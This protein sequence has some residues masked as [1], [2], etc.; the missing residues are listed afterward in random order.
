MLVP[1]VANPFFAEIT[2]SIED[3]SNSLDYGVMICSTDNK[4]RERK[5]IRFSFAQ[6]EKLM[7]L[8]LLPTF[9]NEELIQELLDKKR[10]QLYYWRKKFLVCLLLR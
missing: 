4:K 1:D 2:R 6:A 9:K 5:E 8:S 10:F 7:A 3:Y